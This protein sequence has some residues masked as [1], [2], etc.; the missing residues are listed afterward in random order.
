MFRFIWKTSKQANKQINKTQDSYNRRTAGGS[1][2]P[3]FKLYYRAIVIK[4]TW[5]WNKNR[6]ND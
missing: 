3:N 1:T 6:H 5:Y 4:A 2:I